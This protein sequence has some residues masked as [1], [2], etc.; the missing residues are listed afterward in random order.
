MDSVDEIMNRGRIVTKDGEEYFSVGKMFEG[1]DN[2]FEQLQRERQQ[3]KAQHPPIRNFQSYGSSAG[4]NSRQGYI[5]AMYN[6]TSVA[7]NQYP[8]PYYGA[9]YYQQPYNGYNNNF[10]N[11][12]GYSY[13][14]SGNDWMKPDEE[15][16]VNRKY[17]RVRVIRPGEEPEPFPP[18]PPRNRLKDLPIS[19]RV[20]SVFENV[21]EDGNLVREIYASNPEIKKE[22]E[23]RLYYQDF[24]NAC[25]QS[26]IQKEE[27]EIY[28]LA[29]ELGEYS[30]QMANDLLWYRNTNNPQFDDYKKNCIRMLG[31]FKKHDIKNI[32]NDY[33]VDEQGY[34][35]LKNNNP[36]PYR[37]AT[38]LDIAHMEM[39]RQ[40]ALLKQEQAKLQDLLNN[41]PGPNSNTTG[42]DFIESA[43]SNN[44][45]SPA[46][47]QLAENNKLSKDKQ[48]EKEAFLK[49]NKSQD[50]IKRIQ[51][52]ANLY[53]VCSD[54]V[55]WYE[56]FINNLPPIM[57][58]NRNLYK[59]WK[60]IMKVHKSELGPDESY[61]KW[62][63][64]WWTG[65][66]R[67]N[68]N[69]RRKDDYIDQRTMQRSE[70]LG[71]ISD[72]QPTPNELEQTYLRNWNTMMTKFHGNKIPEHQSM[73]DFFN[74]SYGLGYLENC[75]LQ[76]KLRDQIN[77]TLRLFD[78]GS[79]RALLRNNYNTRI[80]Q[81]GNPEKKPSYEELTTSEAYQQRRQLFISKL[82]TRNPRGTIA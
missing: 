29:T 27:D 15:D 32:F 33:V 16:L 42:K 21:D 75:I 6:N 45:M 79:F 80:N 68:S 43:K 4:W 51:A 76:E 3:F 46:L 7:N 34:V 57:I 39:D 55:E 40:K 63:D 20:Y 61:D 17:P 10:Y 35:T 11:R 23:V 64:E 71:W 37:K 26:Q 78:D 77:N 41:R 69:R 67:I 24:K 22:A 54:E 52:L 82:F 47:I 14:I 49:S 8:T 28:S 72:H 31:E 53:V 58:D 65:G 25:V 44:T 70:R 81:Y 48:K 18:E 5:N 50:V 38:V 60:N 36:N 12:Y 66:K 30:P 2:A 19:Q 9:G 74:G 73:F 62:F 56:N 13:D 59:L 1:D